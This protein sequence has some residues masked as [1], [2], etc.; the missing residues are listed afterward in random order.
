MRGGAGERHTLRWGSNIA[1]SNPVLVL[2]LN[3][4][5]NEKGYQELY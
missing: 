5:E 1:G 4:R 2:S 3:R